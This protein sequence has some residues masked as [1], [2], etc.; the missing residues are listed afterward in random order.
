ML[1]LV[2]PGQ[3]APA[4]VPQTPA[5]PDT[6]NPY[7]LAPVKDALEPFMEK[8]ESM[9]AQAKA[10][11]VV[12]D[13]SQT[14]AVEMA[15]QAKRLGK[16]IEDARKA[17]VAAPNDYVKQVNGLAKGISSPLD[18]IEYVLKGKLRTYADKVEAERRRQ[19]AE[20][21]KAA[22]EAQRLIDEEQRL[23]RE[24]ADRDAAAARAKAEEAAKSGDASAVQLAEI[25]DAEQAK[26]EVVAAVET[27]KVEAPVVPQKTGP[28]H[29]T[30]GSAST[31]KVWKFEVTDA[32]AV[33]REFL[34][35]DEKAIRA[36]VA[37][38]VRQIAGVRIFE[39]TQVAIKA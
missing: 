21:R 6:A 20:A 23:A 39:E 25:A 15:G 1:N 17:Y 7:D 16:A 18:S 3:A 34:L 22:I 24:K 9:A 2:M 29:T 36:A 38:G 5:N 11:E 26:A 14:R 13:A 8:I 19:E 37:A 28:V 10:I 27:V 32:N 4:Y 35:V 33:P 31:K 12:D 30:A